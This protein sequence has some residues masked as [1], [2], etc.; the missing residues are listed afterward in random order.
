[1]RVPRQFC[2]FVLD[3]TLLGVPVDVVQEVLREQPTTPVPLAAPEVA[4]L[5]NLRGQIVTVIDLRVTLGLA[6]RTGAHPVNVVIRTR[7]G[8]VSLLVDR[9]GDVLEPPDAAF[10]APP[11]TVPAALRCLLTAICVLDDR[12]MLVL[13]TELATRARVAS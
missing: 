6:P 1:M 12:L 11:D 4:G 9:V 8:V 3:G 10:E 13:D 2:T 5:M 7:D